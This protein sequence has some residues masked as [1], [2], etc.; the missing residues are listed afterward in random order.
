MN[1]PNLQINF[2]ASDRILGQTYCGD[3]CIDTRKIGVEII[4]SK[5]VNSTSMPRLEMD[6]GA[7]FGRESKFDCRGSVSQLPTLNASTKRANSN[8]IFQ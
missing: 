7:T 8:P 3:T 6:C 5:V 4:W 2:N 1:W